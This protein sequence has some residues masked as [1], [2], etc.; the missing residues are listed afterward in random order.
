MYARGSAALLPKGFEPDHAGKYGT[1]DVVFNYDSEEQQLGATI[2]AVT[3]LPAHKRTGNFSWQVHL[4][5]LPTKKQRVKT[6]IQRGPCPIFTETFRFSHVESEMIGNYAIRFRLYSMR[7]MKKEKVLGEKVFYLTKLNLQG[8]MS[9]PVILDPCCALL[10]SRIKAG[11]G[12]LGIRTT[13]HLLLLCAH[14]SFLWLEN[15][16]RA[17]LYCAA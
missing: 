14:G 17:R 1:L 11:V 6:G 12:F 7:R 3:D 8:K 5:L 2:M 4:V 9:V 10:V 15:I 16:F 13:L